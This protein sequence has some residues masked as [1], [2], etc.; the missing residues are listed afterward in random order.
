MKR[1]VQK[2]GKRGGKR[3]NKN[4]VDD[5]EDEDGDNPQT[6]SSD[7][8]PFIV[9]VPLK[10]NSGLVVKADNP[11]TDKKAAGEMFVF[12]HEMQADIP[13][14]DPVWHYQYGLVLDQDGN[15]NNNYQPGPQFPGDLYQGTDRWY[16]LEY[17]PSSGWSL[18]VRD[19]TNSVITTY[20]SNATAVI[21]G[22]LIQYT[23][24]ADEIEVA[25]PKY[26]VTAYAHKGDFGLQGGDWAMD[27]LPPVDEPLLE[28]FIQE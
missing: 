23:I 10:T 22:S 9:E 14:N 28:G 15:P 12:F 25:N 24:P 8:V 17:T 18:K 3:Y 27:I 13:M 19:A 20:Q 2:K 7:L 26:R 4:S 1:E 11:R 21:D 5:T 6:N 16:S